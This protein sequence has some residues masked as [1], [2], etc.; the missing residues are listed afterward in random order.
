MMK[1]PGHDPICKEIC[2]VLGL[3]HVTRLEFTMQVGH[4]ATVT[5]RYFPEKDGVS[6]FPAI[7]QK[8]K[9]VPIGEPQEDKG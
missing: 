9:L 8:Y 5:A 3:Q 6:Q 4:V 1:I 7:L 2:D